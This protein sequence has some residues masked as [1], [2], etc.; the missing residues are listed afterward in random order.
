MRRVWILFFAC[1]AC[2]ERS[3]Q[4]EEFAGVALVATEEL[5]VGSPDDPETAFTW[6]RELEVGPDGTIYTGHPQE[7]QI[8]MHDAAGRFLGTIGRKGE[9]PGEFTGVG[10]MAIVGDTLWVI[11]DGLYRFSFFDLEG[12]FLGTRRIPIDLGETRTNLPPRPRGLLRDGTITGSPPAFSRLVAS[13][14]ITE[15]V[16]VRM[17]TAGTARDTIVRYSLVNTTWEISNH[18]Q[19]PRGFGSYRLQPFSDTEIV[20]VSDYAMVVVRIT[21]GS[22]DNAGAATF[23]VTATQIDGD[24]IFSRAFAYDPIPLRTAMVDSIV[25]GFAESVANLQFLAGRATY[26]EAVGWAREGLYLP[27]YHPPVSALIMGADGQL[28]LR[29]EELGEP[30]AR[31]RIM[32][33][34]GDP[35]GVVRLPSGF[36]MMYARGMQVWGSEHDELGVPYIVRYRVRETE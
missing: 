33:A 23:A 29:A 19:G 18:E 15:N 22:P 14:E 12:Q 2:A 36:M 30:V 24:T 8:R 21:R 16:I 28:W 26:A 25:N 9:G 13:G 27:A 35:V 34:S 10:T 20:G 6:F 3:G 32:S 31:W 4:T 17:D 5:R 7:Y 11:D 1:L